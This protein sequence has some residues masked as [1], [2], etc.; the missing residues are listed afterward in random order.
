MEYVV[1][2]LVNGFSLTAD[3][4]NNDSGAAFL[5]LLNDNPLTISMQDYGNFEKV[6][7]L[8]TSLPT[9]D[10]RITTEPG[11]IILYLGNY[12]TIYY[13]INSWSFTRL[14]KIRNVDRETLLHYLGNGSVDVTF[15]LPEPTPTP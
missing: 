8:P 14:G 4:V 5:Q 15:A 3:I 6:G 13:D 7:D 2:I 12:I 9:N 11:D 1:E 10:E